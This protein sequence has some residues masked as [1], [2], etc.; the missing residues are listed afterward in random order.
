M[1]VYL[2]GEIHSNWRDAIEDGCK[3]KGLNIQFLKPET[4]H[5][6]SDDAG[7]VL[8]TEDNAF[9]KTTNRPKSIP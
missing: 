4:V 5:N 8:G 2:T 7:D 6:L 3:Q 9:G 1:K